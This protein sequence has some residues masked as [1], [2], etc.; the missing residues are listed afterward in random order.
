MI[1]RYMIQDFPRAEVEETDERLREL[2]L[3]SWEL[4]SVMPGSRQDPTD[5]SSYTFVFRRDASTDIGL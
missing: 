4:V 2:G 3:E 1:F 5:N